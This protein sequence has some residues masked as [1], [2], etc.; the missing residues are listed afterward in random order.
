M[1]AGLKELQTLLV[2]ICEFG[3]VAEGHEITKRFTLN[4]L[5]DKAR[6]FGIK[7]SAQVTPDELREA[8]EAACIR[9]KNSQQTTGS[10]GNPITTKDIF[11]N[12]AGI[13]GDGP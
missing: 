12:T 8:V 7:V 1:T 4:P 11:G 9:A 2:E 10:E 6:S 13:P 5:I 3:A